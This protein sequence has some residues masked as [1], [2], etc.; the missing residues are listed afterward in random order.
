MTYSAM[1][2]YEYLKKHVELNTK[3]KNKVIE[4]ILECARPA[5]F[6]GWKGS[7]KHKAYSHAEAMIYFYEQ[8]LNDKIVMANGKYL[9]LFD[10]ALDKFELKDDLNQLELCSII[11]QFYFGY[12]GVYDCALYVKNSEYL[13][14]GI[15]LDA[16]PS[17]YSV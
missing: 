12:E 5:W 13:N 7:Y 1:E 6:P 3:S 4:Y 2:I 10:Y 8:V 15:H 9:D 17:S 14:C 11:I 16:F